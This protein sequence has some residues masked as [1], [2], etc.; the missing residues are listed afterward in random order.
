MGYD[1]KKHESSK[2][3]EQNF[4]ILKRLTRLD[5]TESLRR[6]DFE[7]SDVGESLVESGHSDENKDAT[8]PHSS[9]FNRIKQLVRNEAVWEDE[10]G[11]KSK[12]HLPIMEYNITVIGLIELLRLCHDR[13]FQQ[14]I[15]ENLNTLPYIQFNI[16]K[17]LSVFSKEQLFETIVSV[18]YNTIIDIDYDPF[19]QQLG[20]GKYGF[21]RMVTAADL[22]DKKD[23]MIVYYIFTEF[24][25]SNFS[26]MVR[27]RIPIYGKLQGKKRIFFKSKALVGISEVVS[28]AFFHELI[29]RCADTKHKDWRYPFAMGRKVVLE[30]IRT[31]PQLM[32]RYSSF[33]QQLN[34]HLQ[35]ETDLLEEI[36]YSV[37]QKKP[38]VKFIKKN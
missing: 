28:C 17:L 12:R 15:F 13:K 23:G 25:K 21:L 14:D 7:R 20:D 27:E 5:Y 38:L 26:Y 29:L 9:L 19:S 1:L 34:L 2:E 10:S 36:E 30:I 16:G 32:K 8:I 3:E 31:D 18:C 24:K 22:L 6:T 37:S 4:I 11:D 35:H 33:L